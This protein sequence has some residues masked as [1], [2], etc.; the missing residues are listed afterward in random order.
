MQ[1]C[2]IEFSG[3]K[4]PN[5]SMMSYAGYTSLFVRNLSSYNFSI[6][7]RSHMGESNLN[8]HSTE[9]CFSGTNNNNNKSTIHVIKQLSD[10]QVVMK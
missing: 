10:I 5:N 1:F 8:A 7:I 3:L 2:Y 6:T 9:K 4:S